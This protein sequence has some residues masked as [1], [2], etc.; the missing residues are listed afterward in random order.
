[1][2]RGPTGAA[3]RSDASVAGSRRRFRRMSARQMATIAPSSQTYR[4]SNAINGEARRHR[5]TS[6]INRTGITPRAFG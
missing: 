4:C 5:P 6:S 1:M 3:E 2:S